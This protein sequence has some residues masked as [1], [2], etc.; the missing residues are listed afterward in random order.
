MK[1]SFALSVLAVEAA[2]V[3]EF[4]FLEDSLAVD[5]ADL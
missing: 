1:L 4:E 5:E 3:P 2:V